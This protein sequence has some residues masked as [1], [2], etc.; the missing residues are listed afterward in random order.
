MSGEIKIGIDQRGD[1]FYAARVSYTTGRPAIKSL[2]RFEKSDIENLTHLG[3]ADLCL[4][5][6][7]Q[8]VTIK[9]IKLNGIDQ[10]NQKKIA[11][12]MSAS[13]TED[14]NNFYYDSLASVPDDFSLGMMIRKDHLDT[15]LKPF[16][17]VENRIDTLIRSA[18]L[19]RGYISFCQHN[20]GGLIALADFNGPVASLAF[21]HDNK[22]LDLGRFNLAPFD[23]EADNG[24][25][26][27]GTE[28]KVYLNF[29]MAAFMSR[30]IS[31]PLSALIISG[32]DL[33]DERRNLL[34]G[35]LKVDIKSPQ[36]NP[37]FISGNQKNRSIP[38]EM[39]LVALGLTVN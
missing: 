25:S 13:V 27:L 1:T 17:K 34:S 9:E 8:Q 22:I 23:L 3:G 11:Y 32:I 10:R 12:E 26:K 16:Q 19:A 33:S 36:I 4:A 30:N 35:R 37:A 31:L 15:L 20:E 18:G 14:E 2:L 21:V 29:K 28:L 24:W 38:L 6:P 7:D 5:A 39:Y